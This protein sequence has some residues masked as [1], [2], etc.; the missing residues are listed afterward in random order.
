MRIVAG[1]YGGRRIRAPSG[2]TT[3]PTVERVREALFNRLGREVLGARVLDAY[4]GSG[5]LGIEAL[6]RGARSAVFVEKAR[7]AAQVLRANLASIGLSDPGQARV[8]EKSLESSVAQLRSIGPFDL[9]LVDPPFAL[10]RDGTV[11]RSLLLLLDSGLL[12]SAG[13]VALEYPSDQDC[14]EVQGLRIEDIRHYGDSRVALM[15]RIEAKK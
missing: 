15:G 3:R 8:I 14:P 5:A 2:D 13:T 11:A 12:D 4:A 7:S 9:W 6:S 10:V 1:L